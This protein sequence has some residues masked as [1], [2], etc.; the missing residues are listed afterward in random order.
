MPKAN[1]LL[2]KGAICGIETRGE[3]DGYRMLAKITHTLLDLI[4]P[5]SCVSC[6]GVVDDSTFKYLCRGCEGKLLWISLSAC[7]RCGAPFEGEVDVGRVCRQCEQLNPV[8]DA[9]RSLF[10]LQGTGKDWIHTLKYRSGTYLR[11]DLNPLLS[12]VSLIEDYLKN[13]LL[14]PVPLHVRK[15][16]ERGFNQSLLIAKGLRRFWPSVKV[17]NCLQRCI[18]TESQT[19]LNR[20]RRIKNMKNAFALRAKCVINP[21]YRYVIVDDVYTTGATLNACARVLKTA[22][23]KRVDIFTLAHG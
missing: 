2:N 5:R 14:V 22:G 21:N 8:F 20:D 12:S 10:R 1:L 19:C 7:E 23:A 11:R 3:L 18:D 16:R 4:Y 9:G 13:A 6:L 15:H 17:I